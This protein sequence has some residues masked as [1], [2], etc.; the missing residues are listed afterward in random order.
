MSAIMTSRRSA[1]PVNVLVGAGSSPP[2]RPPHYSHRLR[3]CLAP[4][5]NDARVATRVQTRTLVAI[6]A[7][8]RRLLHLI[9]KVCP[10]EGL[11]GLFGG[12][13]G[14]P[15]KADQEREI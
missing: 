15:D 12:I 14:H 6:P 13:V 1:S 4:A 7:L 2:R 3:R 11:A 10:P 9:R 5:L 8:S